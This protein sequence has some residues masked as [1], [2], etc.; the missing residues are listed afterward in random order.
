[1]TD[2][3]RNSKPDT[4]FL[5][6]AALAGIETD[7]S[8]RR[9]NLA[10]AGDVAIEE[11][12]GRA[13][14]TYPRELAAVVELVA[15]DDGTVLY[16]G[17]PGGSPD[18][19]YRMRITFA[20]ALECAEE[21]ALRVSVPI[22]GLSP[23]LE[24][25]IVLHW[26]SRQEGAVVRSEA[27]AHNLDTGE[28]N[29]A[30]AVHAPGGTDGGWDLVVGGGAGDDFTGGLDRIAYARVSRRF[31]STAEAR[32]DWIAETEP[33]EVSGVRRRCALELDRQEVDLAEDGQLAGPVYLWAGSA[34]RDNDRRCNSPLV[35]LRIAKVTEALVLEK[36]A[37]PANWIRPSPLGGGYVIALPHVF[38]R[39]ARANR[40]HVR[41]F[42]RQTID[43]GSETAG[44]VTYRML[45][46]HLT[47]DASSPEQLADSMNA[48]PAV[49]CSSHHISAGEGEWLDLGDVPLRVDA[50]GMVWLML[51]WKFGDGEVAEGTEAVVLA[52]TADPFT[53]PQQDGLDKGA[54]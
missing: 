50:W 27:M 34:A 2:L 46:T 29:I 5:G 41:I 4:A 35:N 7:Q 25:R 23:M 42:V 6:D 37:G 14:L 24:R 53:V 1:M 8:E 22:P 52:L 18:Y 9:T 49:T 13:A 36:A 20:G 3:H 19:T 47:P 10:I 40:A 44:P 26:S 11:A 51:S 28:T 32:E 38:Y 54:P 43:G 12:S 33:P 17:D 48:G 15:G 31:H 21:G 39:P 16:H 45:S 30:V